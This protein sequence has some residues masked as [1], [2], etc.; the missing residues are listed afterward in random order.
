MWT[1]SK[2]HPNLIRTR[3]RRKCFGT[4]MK[5]LV[6]QTCWN[7]RPELGWFFFFSLSQTF[8]PS[9]AG[10][11]YRFEEKNKCGQFI[12]GLEKDNSQCS[13][14]KQPPCWAARAPV[15]TALV[16]CWTESENPP[17]SPSTTTQGGLENRERERDRNRGRKGRKGRSVDRWTPVVMKDGGG[18]RCRLRTDGAREKTGGSV[19]DST[20]QNRETHAEVKKRPVRRLLFES[21]T[22]TSAATSLCVGLSSH[23]VCYRFSRVCATLVL[24]ASSL[25]SKPKHIIWCDQWIA[26]H[27]QTTEDPR[28][29]QRLN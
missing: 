16:W 8:L 28:Q 15:D 21:E 25:S 29:T 22:T 26:S 2:E 3:K 5:E 17:S 7:Q 11:L 27:D 18:L 19:C 12:L 6:G 23:C 24:V 10:C 20:R 4:I 1:L 9:C 14:F 13:M